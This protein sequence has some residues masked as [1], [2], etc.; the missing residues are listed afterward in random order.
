MTEGERHFS[1]IARTRT[2]LNRNKSF[3]V[4]PID[5]MGRVSF[6]DTMVAFPTGE[7]KFR[8]S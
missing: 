7:D 2:V 4:R 5:L 6:D 3:L 1:V 8:G